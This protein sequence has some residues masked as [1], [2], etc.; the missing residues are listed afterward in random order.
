MSL[1]QSL[2]FLDVQRKASSSRSYRS[3]LAPSNAKDFECG[4]E[5][6]WDLPGNLANSYYDL[7]GTAY[8]T[9]EVFNDSDQQIFF[10]G[11]AGAYSLWNRMS[12]TTAGATLSNVTNLNNLINILFST[13]VSPQY[14]DNI[15][16]HLIGTSKAID[17]GNAENE[18]ESIAAGGKRKVC[19]PLIC[20]GITQLTPARYLPAF[21]K[22]RLQIRLQ[23]EN[24]VTAFFA[25]ATGDVAN[26]KVKILNAEL[27][28]YTCELAPEVNASVMSMTGGKFEMM[29]NEWI[30]AKSSV[31]VNAAALTAT[32]GFT[33]GSL[34]S[35]G[36]SQRTAAHIN[37]VTKHSFARVRNY[38]DEWQLAVNGTLYPSRPILTSGTGASEALAELLCSRHEV[39]NFHAT[40]QVGDGY[41]VDTYNGTASTEPSFYTAVELESFAQT[42]RVY[43]GI[44]TVSA[45]TQLQLK[46]KPNSTVACE[47]DIYGLRSVKYVLNMADLGT[48]E[49]YV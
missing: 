2:N 26:N 27:T 37:D 45:T 11:C 6:V 25:G 30:A 40:S 14:T 31:G 33:S 42:D 3:K 17:T 24:A 18:G 23:L 19:L 4:N 29:A 36:F 9:F 41:A 15:G 44:N 48:Y 1:P 22:D 47:I 46:F 8:V 10:D 16:Q 43:A 32:L 5:I 49:V 34:E 28:F 21:S 35:V 13:T 7:G 38:L 39:H 12:V 20:L